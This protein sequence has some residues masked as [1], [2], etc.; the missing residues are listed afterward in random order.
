MVP[1]RPSLKLKDS[2]SGECA[3]TDGVPK[4]PAAVPGVPSAK[5]KWS[6]WE[7]SSSSP[8]PMKLEEL[9]CD[10]SGN[11]SDGSVRSPSLPL[12]KQDAAGAILRP[13]LL[14]LALT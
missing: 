5:P 12:R 13:L 9:L 11:W 6:T 10:C 3:V 8:F 1:S 14:V 7:D 4:G 2:R